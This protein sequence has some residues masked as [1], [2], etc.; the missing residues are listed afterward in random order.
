MK[1]GIQFFLPKIWKILTNFSFEGSSKDSIRSYIKRE[2]Q[3]FII[4]F[5]YLLKIVKKPEENCVGT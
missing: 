5:C 1:E 2:H 4:G 3:S